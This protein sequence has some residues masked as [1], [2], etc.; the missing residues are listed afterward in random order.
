MRLSTKIAI[1][2]IL[3]ALAFYLPFFH[4]TGAN[5]VGIQWNKF[6]GSITTD[7][8][9]FNV[10]SPWVLVAKVDTRPQRVC[11]ESVAKVINCKLAAIR[12]SAYRQLVAREG[13]RYYWWDNRLSFNFGYGNEYR[14]TRDLVRAYA[15]SPTQQEFVQIFSEIQE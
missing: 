10:T 1:A 6:D 5:Q 12:P 7:T 13:F 11:V 15:F 4:Y 3:I 8:P 14:G 2:A 9:G